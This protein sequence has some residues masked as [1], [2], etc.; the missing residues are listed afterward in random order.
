MTEVIYKLQEENSHLKKMLLHV[1][2][3]GSNHNKI[4]TKYSS[5]EEKMTLYTSLFKGRSDVFAER[6]T[7]SL[8]KSG[9]SPVC[10]FEWQKPLCEKPILKCSECKHQQF[11]P[12]NK[13]HLM[14]HMNGERTIGLYPILK[15][16]SCFFLAIDFDE[17]DWKKDVLL[18][19]NVCKKYAVDCYIERSRSG[20][21]AHVWIFFETSI[22]ARIARALGQFLLDKTK[23]IHGEFHLNS[24]DRMFP[25]QDHLPEGGLGNLIA[26]PLQ[27][28]AALKGNSLF[29]DESFRAYPDQWIYF[30]A[31]KKM[32][33]NEVLAILKNGY[34]TEVDT[35]NDNIYVNII[36]KNGLYIPRKLL[37]KEITNK[38][39]RI[40]TFSNPNYYKAKARRASTHNIP[41]RIS[42]VD[43][44]Q[45]H[46]I[47]PRG[48]RN[49]VETL[50]KKEKVQF[51]ITNECNE[52]DKIS[53]NF[54]GSLTTQQETVKEELSQFRYGTLSA[55]TGFGKTVVAASIIAKRQMNTLIIVHRTQ[56]MKQWSEQL[57]S[58]LNLS[59]DEVGQLGG[60]KNTINGHIDIATIQS[61]NYGGKLKSFI[62]NYGQI[63]VDE[64]HMIS[65]VTFE[66]VMKQVRPT[67]IL[68]L[69]ATPKRRDGYEPI[70]EM[71]CGPIRAVID[72]K[73]QSKVRPFR[74]T[75]IERVTNFNTK[76]ESIN[77]IYDQMGKSSSR[78]NQI[79]N[80]VLHSLEEGRSPI[81]LTE[82]I[83][84]LQI[85]EEMFQNF[86]KNIIV[87]S[88]KMTQKERALAMNKLK[89]VP[90]EE[91]RLILSTGKY[92]GEGFDDARLDTL[93]LSMPISWKGTL[94]QY[95]GRLHRVYK[96]KEEVQVYDYVDQR[97]PV[98]KNMYKKRFAGYKSMGYMIKG[99]EKTE[100]MQLF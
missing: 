17:R 5:L 56:L 26:L 74:H 91:E 48:C 34:S 89:A 67:Y 96:T 57:S 4:I 24:Y 92:I 42:C 83:E 70:I 47:I 71:Q 9:Y 37:T 32:N 85:L 95:V 77:K 6:W 100:Q 75:L 63:I 97:V 99:D 79:F 66:E 3:N 12:F 38:L 68:G 44:T 60:G 29:V 20:N 58:F 52:G 64:C 35:I 93:F 49:D 11:I 84:H 40:A 55:T 87:L 43:L 21:G 80:D 23:E 72:A 50:F 54:Y 94:Q 81:I 46:I 62:T 88:G 39:E 53:V 22:Q 86:V 41:K 65:A 25:N 13:E 28:E 10:K 2:G 51:S 16:H 14:Q 30:S 1:M 78:N 33:V 76:E 8:G 7:S 59:N 82:R 19:V 69:T 27:K 31:I 18:F 73:T 61:L 90:A 15:D 36:E 98:L 45:S